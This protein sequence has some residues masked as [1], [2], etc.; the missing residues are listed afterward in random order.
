MRC[1]G[2]WQQEVR[3]VLSVA[4][5]SLLLHGSASALS[6][7]AA[8]T[9][10]DLA[11]QRTDRYVPPDP[12][13]FFP[14]DPEGGRR[15][16]ALFLAG[17]R[18]QRSEEEM[19]STV[20]Q[21][22]R[23][24]TQPRGQVLALLSKRC[25]LTRGSKYPQ[26]VEVLYHAVPLQ[27][28][29]A[30]YFAL[31]SVPAKTPNLLHALA[32]LCL[33]G[34]AVPEITRGIGS[35]REELLSYITPHL[36]DPD[37]GRREIAGVLVQHFRG[38]LDFEEWQRDRRLEQVK[39]KFG[40]QLP[41]FQETLRTGSSAA[42]YG[43]LTTILREAIAPILDDSF[44][45]ALQ[46][47]GDDPD[48]RVRSEVARLVGGRWVLSPLRQA[49]GAREREE[50]RDVRAQQMLAASRLNPDV[51]TLLLKLASDSDR[52]VRYDA[53]YGGLAVMHDKSEAVIRRLLEVALADPQ[54]NLY[55]R[56]T[57]SLRTSADAKRPLIERN[58]AVALAA[59]Q[60]ESE[61]TTIR[62]LY[63]EVF[64][65]ELS[66]ADRESRARLTGPQTT[67]PDSQTNA[68]SPAFGPIQRQINEAAPGA[69][70]RLEPGVYREPLTIDKSLV[71]EGAGWDKTTILV[72]SRAAELFEQNRRV[73]ESS[74][75]DAER[76]R[77]RLTEEVGQP[78]LT[79]VGARG[80]TVRGIKFSTPG[81]RAA[82]QSLPT[83][84]IKLSHCD[85]RLS[86]CAVIAGPGDGIRVFDQS[87]ATI[88]RCLVAAVWG[89]GIAVGTGQDTSEARIANSDVRNCHYA[90]IRIAR[91]NKAAIERCRVSGAAWHGI[92]YDDASPQI[93]GNLIFGNARS[94]IYAS[95]QTAA[96]VKGNLF[97]DNEMGGMSCWF[98]N[99]D[100]IEGNTFA[101]NKQA[102]LTILGA[103][104]PSI[105]RNI[106]YA[107]SAGVTRADVGDKSPW[108][109]SD[110]SI[111]LED[112]LF[113]AN[114]HDVQ[115][116][117][118]P[119]AFEPVALDGKT[120][121]A[122]DPQFVAPGAKDYSLKTDSPARQKGIG[123]ADPISG[124]SPWPLQPQE[125]AIVPQGD[126]RD[127]RQWRDPP[128]PSR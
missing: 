33:Q 49:A 7:P 80:V 40:S 52:N 23:R 26:A 68:P 17:D 42:R 107:D 18:E 83:A 37:P 115:K 108:A 100:L 27:P 126:T 91:N 121:L 30:V 92:R 45:P 20:R 35:Q 28:H 96:V 2:L 41:Q 25:L 104:K 81:R 4:A 79:I 51:V 3:A 78:A 118:T 50:P 36:Q 86:D 29:E 48:P 99:G 128:A 64:G 116:G 1:S 47:A 9:N 93:M 77:K 127:W 60:T 122:V 123:V 72:E 62:G 98:Q 97:Y 59:A 84:I 34:Q 75:E 14:D 95:G 16:D 76:L 46:A 119:G 73:A 113:W 6:E 12:N 19:L 13:G 101:N 85:V 21:G 43:V 105:R 55:S 70:I 124:T 88:E 74:R 57:Q 89:T 38:E 54:G 71:L 8:A 117:A 39:A 63:R 69:T 5:L 112:N 44:L 61:K 110:G 106:F 94:G 102:G 56:I 114:E 31:A 66:A 90:G 87:S 53:V 32:D 65:Q 82:G 120:G 10:G 109:K 11:W 125:R 103:S 22:F 111:T 58:L 67:A 24:T 15:L